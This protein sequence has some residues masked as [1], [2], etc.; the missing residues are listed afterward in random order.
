MWIWLFYS[1]AINF[2]NVRRTKWRTIRRTRWRTQRRTSENRGLSDGQSVRPSERH[3]RIHHGHMAV[4]CMDPSWIHRGPMVVPCM[5]PSWIYRGPMADTVVFF[6]KSEGQH[7][8]SLNSKEFF[9]DFKC[10][11]SRY[12][13]KTIVNKDVIQVEDVFNFGDDRSRFVLKFAGWARTD[14]N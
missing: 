6:F 7:P 10:I 5:S 13:S 9:Q 3:I 11:I 4:P 1:I 8:N 14:L 2:V 12:Q